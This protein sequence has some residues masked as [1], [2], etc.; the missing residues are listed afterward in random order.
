MAIHKFKPRMSP[1]T[2][3][4]LNLK[5]TI[6]ISFGFLSVLTAL[7]Y[8]NFAVPLILADMIP[9]EFIFIV[10]AK[11]TI[12]GSIMTIDNILAVLLQPYFGAL[13][14]RTQSKFGRRMPYIIVGILG[15]AFTFAIAP[16]IKALLGFILILF[17][18]NLLMA[19]H[20]TPALTLLADY[21]P[22]Q[23][24][25]TG[26]AIQQFVSNMGTIIAF[27]IPIVVDMLPVSEDWDRSLGFLISSVFMVIFLIILFLTIKETPTGVGIFSVSNHPIQIDSVSFNIIDQEIT[28]DSPSESKWSD[29]LVIFNAEEKSTLWILLA[30][31]FWF[32]G[33]GAIEAF[34]SLFA[35]EYLG[36]TKGQAGTVILVYPISMILSSI[37]T[38][39]LG[40]RIGR[41][42]SLIIGILGMIV[43]ASLISFVAVP[44][45][46]VPLLTLLLGI[47]GFF[48]MDVIVNTFPVV[49]NLAPEGKKGGYTG[50]YYTFNQFAA[51]VSP[52][53]IGLVLD[54]GLWIGM[55]ADRFLLMFP[56]VVVCF[57]IAFFFLRM[58]KG[59]EVA[60]R[61]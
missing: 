17:I 47:I 16:W 42:K 50:I 46:N 60:N 22:D 48:W 9:N 33:F 4:E 1:N 36:L 19:L 37:P 31:F 23:V 18:F 25:S 5:R 51:I 45:K 28:K 49:W 29:F 61:S 58:M 12:I 2:P 56:Y 53:L 34:F 43:I 35:T 6:F 27:L 39:I 3:T 54:I 32:T 7:T 40:Q 10:F 24:R 13:S 55:G 57:I 14:D 41:K 20:R 21:T 11:N 52:P 26:S 8:Y 59:G 38:G 15:C 30:V 44:Q